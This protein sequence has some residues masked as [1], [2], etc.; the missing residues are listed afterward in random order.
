[1]NNLDNLR[2]VATVSVVLLLPFFL[3]ACKVSAGCEGGQQGNV[4]WWKCG[5]T[6]SHEFWDGSGGSPYIIEGPADELL[7]TYGFL[8][9]MGIVDLTVNTQPN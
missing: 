1:M 2:K 8:V 6:A 7:S 4:P 5:V 9:D 3:G